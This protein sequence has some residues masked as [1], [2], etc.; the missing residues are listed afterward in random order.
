MNAL[1]L[2]GYARCGVDSEIRDDAAFLREWFSS[3]WYWY[4]QSQKTR[5]ALHAM[6]GAKA[7]LPDP[8][9][10]TREPIRLV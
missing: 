9:K 8:Q 7:V 10:W 2:R 1:A 3:Y 4:N 6:S 5:G